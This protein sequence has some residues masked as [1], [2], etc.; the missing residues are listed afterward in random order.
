MPRGGTIEI[1]GTRTITIWPRGFGGSSQVRDPSDFGLTQRADDLEAARCALGI[2]RWTL[3]GLSMG[4]FVALLYALKHPAAVSA[5]VLDST[6][7]SYAYALDRDSIWPDL[8]ASD[9]GH[10]YASDASPQNRSQYF[11]KM[12]D[13]QRAKDPEYRPPDDLEVNDAALAYILRNLSQYDVRGR[14]REIAVPALVLAGGRDGQCAPG[15]SREIADAVAGAQ[16]E[17]FPE[18][19]HGIIRADRAPVLKLVSDFVSAAATPW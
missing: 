14:L 2:G 1:P 4:G 11:A 18:L 8:A 10:R 3:W 7:P 19:G 15:Q 16:I 9:E 6:A 12:R 5:L 13:L 17:F